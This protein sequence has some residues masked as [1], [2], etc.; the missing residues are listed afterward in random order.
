MPRQCVKKNTSPCPF[1]INE[2]AGEEGLSNT[3]IVRLERTEFT[4]DNEGKKEYEKAML[5]SIY[6]SLFNAGKISFEQL[7]YLENMNRKYW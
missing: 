2:R 4:L 7:K 6:Q 5:L 3:K 1:N